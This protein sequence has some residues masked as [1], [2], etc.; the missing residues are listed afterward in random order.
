MSN[1]HT[2]PIIE[3]GGYLTPL[4]INF[5]MF[6]S[7]FFA[8]WILLTIYHSYQTEMN[9]L[10]GNTSQLKW[11]QFD[12]DKNGHGKIWVTFSNRLKKS[13][14]SSAIEKRRCKVRLQI[15]E[16]LGRRSQV[17]NSVSVR[18]LC[19]GITVKMYLPLVICKHKLWFFVP[20]LLWQKYLLP[21]NKCSFVAFCTL[22]SQYFETCFVLVLTSVPV[23]IFF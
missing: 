18:T 8:H 23:P 14:Y 5:L 9:H 19:F 4:T 15:K 2:N 21:W 3:Y 16:E 12:L 1:R 6:W 13:C 17:Q 10:N 20:N 7:L 22:Q 11:V